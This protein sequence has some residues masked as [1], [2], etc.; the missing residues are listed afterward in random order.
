MYYFCFSLKIPTIVPNIVFS[1]C[2]FM[3]GLYL[4]AV[5]NYE[6]NSVTHKYLIRGHTQNEGDAVHSVIEKCL[7]KAKTSGPIYIPQQ[8]V[9][10]I[11]SAKKKGNPFV[12]QELTFT[13][14]IDLKDLSDQLRLNSTKNTNGVQIKIS[15]I[16]MLRFEKGSNTY[17]YK[18]SYK[19]ENWESV[20]IRPIGTRRSEGNIAKKV[21]LKAAYQSKREISDNKI[22]DLKH[23]LKNN[24]IPKF[25]EPFFNDLF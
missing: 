25:Y 11:R 18:T 10:L 9:T 15:A 17:Y 21:K 20:L 19:Q 14:F 24:Y 4:Y 8:Y 12:V 7:K 23:L 2:R 5:E 16:K 1:Y 22:T 13:D 6:I 3:L